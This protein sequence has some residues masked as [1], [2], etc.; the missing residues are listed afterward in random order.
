MNDI[1]FAVMSWN[2]NQKIFFKFLVPEFKL[3]HKIARN[4]ASS[5]D[6]TVHKRSTKE[7]DQKFVMTSSDD[8]IAIPL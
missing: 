2:Y 7:V 4:C 3:Q 1:G 6:D 5:T 8:G